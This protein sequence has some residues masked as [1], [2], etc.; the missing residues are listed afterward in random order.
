MPDNEIIFW[1]SLDQL[2]AETRLVIDRPQGSPH[3]RYAELIY[4]YDYGYL[5]GT[6]SMDGGGIDVWRGSLEGSGLAGII[7]TIDRTKRDS[8]IKLLI[9]CTVEEMQ[10]ILAFHNDGKMSGILILRPD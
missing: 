5:E 10:N 9:E 3:P 1:E 4:P 2:I 7:I 8:E 6:A